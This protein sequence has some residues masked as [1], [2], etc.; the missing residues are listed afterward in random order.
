MG[1]IVSFQ[2][3]LTCELFAAV[4]ADGFD[5]LMP[6]LEVSYEVRSV[7]ETSIALGTNH[8]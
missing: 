4:V 8:W 3:I 1:Q 7:E 2:S 6:V 5:P